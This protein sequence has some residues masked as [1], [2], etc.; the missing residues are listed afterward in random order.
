VN[1]E[2][3]GVNPKASLGNLKYQLKRRAVPLKHETAQ[4]LN[5]EIMNK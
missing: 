4:C 1:N 2:I 3:T 5:P